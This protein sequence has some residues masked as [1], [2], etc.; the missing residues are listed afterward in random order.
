MGVLQAVDAHSSLTFAALER[1]MMSARS[2]TLAQIP[3]ANWR[4]PIVGRAL[5]VSC[6]CLISYVE[7]TAVLR[8]LRSSLTTT[9]FTIVI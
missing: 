8:Q 1:T 9:S 7:A 5:R 2:R 6:A 4:L 3:R